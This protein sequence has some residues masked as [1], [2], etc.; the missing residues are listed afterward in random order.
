MR[1]TGQFLGAFFVAAAVFG[2]AMLTPSAASAAGGTCS[3]NSGCHN[4]P[5][6]CLLK[7]F[8]ALGYVASCGYRSDDG[9]LPVCPKVG[10]ISC[11]GTCGCVPIPGF[12][13]T[14]GGAD[15]C[16]SGPP[17][18]GTDTATA[19]TSVSD[20]A[21]A[22]T[23]TADTATSDTAVSDTAVSDTLV[24]TGTPVDSA[25]PVDT[26][27]PVDSAP[28]VD[29]GTPADSAPPIDTGTPVDST[30]PDD[31]GTPPVDAPA[32]TCVPSA[33]PPGT[34]AV[35]IA[36]ECDPFC[37]QPCGTGEFK[38]AGLTGT[39]CSDGFCIPAC[40]LTGCPDCQRCS[41][42]D[43]KCF[44]DT[45]ACADAGSDGGGGDGTASDGGTGDGSGG[46]GSGDDASGGDGGVDAATVGDSSFGAD[47][48]LDGAPGNPDAGTAPKGGC[49][50]EI[51]GDSSTGSNAALLAA[52]A[53][54]VVF[55]RRRRGRKAQ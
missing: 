49:G 41:I 20:T 28:P 26:G 22:D 8:C 36:G 52:A 9:G 13:E 48:D 19:D 3:C 30:P 24:D 34:K 5:G 54:M 44:D 12:C 51:P 43:G 53:A 38:C 23:A 42:G 7:N 10:Y 25:P 33:C 35:V 16:D 2:T 39:K 1:T 50:C 11:D 29:T 32:D 18:T 46:D 15:Y 6:M 14:V 4:S 17:D 27:T 21:T 31:T 40:L 37:A 55:A 47:G 45:S